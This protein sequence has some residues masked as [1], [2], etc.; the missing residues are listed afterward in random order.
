M[1]A[2]LLLV[3]LVL[4][5]AAAHAQ[6]APATGRVE[7][8]VTDAA[9]GRPVSDAA[10]VVP[11][12]GLEARTDRDGRYRLEALPP[13]LHTVV[14]WGDRYLVHDV[15]VEVG[16]GETACL[17]AAMTA[18]PPPGCVV[19]CGPGPPPVGVGIYAARVVTFAES[20]GCCEVRPVR[21]DPP[22]V[23]WADR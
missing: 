1:R 8:V 23:R 3:L 17:D 7:G 16:A 20:T 6:P 15:T 2:S 19:L 10:V 5:A 9:T 18:L 11:A 12:L 4:L 22:L 14:T 21:Y 13:G